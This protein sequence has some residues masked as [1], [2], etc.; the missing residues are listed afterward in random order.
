M[1]FFDSES[2]NL[3]VEE[4]QEESTEETQEESTEETQEEPTEETQEEPTEE[5]QEDLT[6][7]TQEESTEEIQEEST[8]E[9]TTYEYYQTVSATDVSYN[10]VSEVGF[11]ESTTICFFLLSA[12]LGVCLF[13]VFKS[14]L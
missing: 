5:T 1:M 6:E 4:T 9:N 11:Y 2:E 3:I 8:E 10:G 13:N 7:E 12:I 14:K